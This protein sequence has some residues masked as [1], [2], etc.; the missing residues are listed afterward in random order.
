MTPES[1]AGP[2]NV[3]VSNPNQKV[4]VL[5]NGFVYTEAASAVPGQALVAGGS[6][7]VQSSHRAEIVTVGEM[8]SPILTA[9]SHRIATIGIQ[10][11][12]SGGN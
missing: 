5:T 7:N 6:V 12:L 3:A 1:Q 2:V 10:A 4:S 11:V 8:G 9:S